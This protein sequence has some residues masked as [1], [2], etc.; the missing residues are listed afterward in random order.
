MLNKLN[1]LWGRKL[2]K[3]EF[4]SGHEAEDEKDAASPQMSTGTKSGRH[5]HSLSY[6]LDFILSE[7]RNYELRVL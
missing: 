6:N 5:D 7:L 4:N 2:D 3:N 1:D